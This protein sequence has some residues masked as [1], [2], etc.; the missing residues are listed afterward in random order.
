VAQ[1]LARHG[2]VRLT[3]GRA[4]AGPTWVVPVPGHEIDVKDVMEQLKR[5]GR[6]FGFAAGGGGVTEGGPAWYFR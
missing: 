6:P 5:Q 2:W 3:S 4:Q 1:Y